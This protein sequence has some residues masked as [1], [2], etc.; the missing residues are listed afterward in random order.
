MDAL[1]PIRLLLIRSINVAAG[2]TQL[3][4]HRPLILRMSKRRI[5]NKASIVERD[6]ALRHQRLV[7]ARQHS[8]KN[9]E[10]PKPRNENR[11][12][13]FSKNDVEHLRCNCLPFGNPRN[14]ALECYEEKKSDA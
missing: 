13:S 14:D 7:L 3:L 1:F 11:Q 5:G 10:R 6:R 2:A 4:N 8:D 12:Q 9:K